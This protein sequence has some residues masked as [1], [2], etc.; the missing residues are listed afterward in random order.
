LLQRAGAPT[1]A[2]DEASSVVFGMPKAAI[3]LKAAKQILPL[4][5]IGAALLAAAGHEANTTREET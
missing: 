1:I 2:Q 5:L 3:E 4:S